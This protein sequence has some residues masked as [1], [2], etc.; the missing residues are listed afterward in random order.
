MYGQQL[1]RQFRVSDLPEYI[2]FNEAT[3]PK[4]VH[5]AH[6]IGMV[7]IQTRVPTEGGLREELASGVAATWYYHAARRRE[8]VKVSWGDRHSEIE[9]V[10][11]HDADDDRRFNSQAG[12]FVDEV[13]RRALAAQEAIDSGERVR[14]QGELDAIVDLADEW[15]T[16]P[17][18]EL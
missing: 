15:R 6:L 1:P 13:W 16:T 5:L 11:P 18:D 2:D 9:T 7:D 3:K 8:D 14:A 10:I 4:H 17:G 12:E